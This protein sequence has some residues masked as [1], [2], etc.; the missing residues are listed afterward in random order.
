MNQAWGRPADVA[1]YSGVE[2]RTV[3]A[4]MKEGLPFSRLPS[5]RIL[6]AFEDL[7]AFLKSFQVDAKKESADMSTLADAMV[8][9]IVGAS[10]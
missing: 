10:S 8:L 7:N 5:G 1:R 4:W 3:Y 9:K 6:I 2:K